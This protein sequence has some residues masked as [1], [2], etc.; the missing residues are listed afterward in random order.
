MTALKER[1]LNIDPKM[2]VNSKSFSEAAGNEALEKIISTSG[3]SFT[4]IV[5]AN[6]LLALGCFDVLTAH[7]LRCPLDVSVTGYNHMPFVNR[8]APSLTTVHIPHH[9]LG[10]KSAELLLE[11]IAHP[12]TKPRTVCLQPKLMVA[13]STRAIGTN[14]WRT[15]IRSTKSLVR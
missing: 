4:A 2:I 12:E 6:D 14:E 7:G 1:G 8:F 15:S 5:A 9:E 3:V 13:D 11:R 10:T